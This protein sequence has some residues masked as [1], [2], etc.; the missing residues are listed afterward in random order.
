MIAQTIDVLKEVSSVHLGQASKGATVM[1]WTSKFLSLKR[2]ALVSLLASSIMLLCSVPRSG[3]QTPPDA[4]KD[5][6]NGTVTDTKTGMTWQKDDT[7]KTMGWND[8]ISYCRGLT[9]AKYSNWRLPSDDELTAL[10]HNA[11]AVN[12]IKTKYFPGMKPAPYW[13]SSGIG[14][15]S[16]VMV[17][18][19]DFTNGKATGVPNGSGGLYKAGGPFYARCVREQPK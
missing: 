3:A 13:S 4:L 17:W 5:N 19:V 11:G 2:P 8:A 18:A 6:G 9:L 10:W 16:G 14:G 15:T 12:E 1:F 7:G